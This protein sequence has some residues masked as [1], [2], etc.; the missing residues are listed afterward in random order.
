[1]K[2]TIVM[3]TD[4]VRLSLWDFHC[5][6]AWKH[7]DRRT[8]C[9]IHLFSASHFVCPTQQRSLACYMLEHIEGKVN[10]SVLEE[11]NFQNMPEEGITD[12]F[13]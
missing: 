2:G 11:F 9:L 12:R 8:I 3:K 10:Q 13:V 5:I 6:F 4:D 1:M 7:N